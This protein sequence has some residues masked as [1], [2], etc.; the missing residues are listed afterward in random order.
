VQIRETTTCGGTKFA[1]WVVD[2]WWLINVGASDSYSSYYPYSMVE[3]TGC[4][5]AGCKD[6]AEKSGSSHTSENAWGYN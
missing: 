3:T 1:L 6:W 5:S 4:T 2:G